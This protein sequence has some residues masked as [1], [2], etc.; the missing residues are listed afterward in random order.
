MKLLTISDSNNKYI[1]EF[2]EYIGT[3]IDNATYITF[4]K[5]LGFTDDSIQ[6]VW[7][8]GKREPEKFLKVL[9]VIVFSVWAA[10]ALR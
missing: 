9:S 10:I 2:S 8:W 7:N 5:S 4:A 1:K 6:A 3:Q